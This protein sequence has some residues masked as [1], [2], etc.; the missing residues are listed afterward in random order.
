MLTAE[1]VD[2]GR[3]RF[4]GLHRFC[5]HGRTRIAAPSRRLWLKDSEM[6]KARSKVIAIF[7]L[8]SDCRII[9][10]YTTAKNLASLFPQL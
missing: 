8:Q 4:V 7:A 9:F 10:R 1:G 6:P 3:L 5:A 2:R